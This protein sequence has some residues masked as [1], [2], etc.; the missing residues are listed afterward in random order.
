MYRTNAK[1]MGVYTCITGNYDVLPKHTYINTDYDY[2]CF[3][4]NKKLLKK[5]RAE[6]GK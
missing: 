6:C 4:D 2:V 3:T 5:K 1:R